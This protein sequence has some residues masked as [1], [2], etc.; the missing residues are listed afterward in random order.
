MRDN[1][2]KACA[3]TLFEHARLYGLEQVYWEGLQQVL[4][5]YRE[6]S[7]IAGKIESSNPPNEEWINAL[8]R[9]LPVEIPEEI[10]SFFRNICKNGYVGSLQCFAA[11]YRNLLEASRRVGIAKVSTKEYLGLDK[12][13]T[14]KRQLEKITGASVI[15]ECT[16]NSWMLE[17]L[18]VEMNGQILEESI[19]RPLEEAIFGSDKSSSSEQ[20]A[21]LDAEG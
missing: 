4:Q 6:N 14:L 18:V 10:T 20:D 7:E 13:E 8:V 12:K 16:T 17:N 19:R 15:M 11:E 9:F 5:V 1:V 21:D 2:I 3:H